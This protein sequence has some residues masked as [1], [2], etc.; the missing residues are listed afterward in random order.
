VKSI[1]AQKGV[2]A[3]VFICDNGSSDHS[4]QKIN[5]L[6]SKLNLKDNNNLKIN[7]ANIDLTGKNLGYAAA[8]NRLLSQM[9]APFQVLCNMDLEF[10][11]DWAK[12][13]LDAFERHPEAA[14]VASLVMEKSGVVNALGVEFMSDLFA[15]N[16]GS[17]EALDTLQPLHEKPV[18]GCY[19]AV[20][21]FRREAA[22]KAGPLEE[23]FFLFFE[24][25]EWYLRQNLLGLSTVLCPQ[26]VVWHERSKTTVRYSPLKLYYGERNRIA[27]ACAYMPLSFLLAMPFRSCKRYLQMAKTLKTAKQNSASNADAKPVPPIS[28]IVILR[29][30][31]KAWLAGLFGYHPQIGPAL[32]GKG[33][34]KRALETVRQHLASP[35]CRP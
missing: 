13:V 4:I 1:L 20:M 5:E 19:G 16:E 33:Y 9:S 24:E 35:G 7:I 29:T 8:C 27:T 22:Q 3:R 11:E 10:A 14:S 12:T 31:I 18:F 15:V 6:I 21:A 25:T 2:E 30:L 28:K 23:K 34:R 17:G 32:L 26:A